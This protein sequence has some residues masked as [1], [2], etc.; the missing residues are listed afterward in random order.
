[1]WRERVII[2]TLLMRIGA[3]KS[4]KLTL[5]DRLFDRNSAST[6]VMYRGFNFVMYFHIEVTKC[7]CPL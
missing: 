7:F 3:Y 4:C 1:V 5:F 6:W 2:A